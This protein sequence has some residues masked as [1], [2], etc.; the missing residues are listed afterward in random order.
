MTHIEMSCII[1]VISVL[2]VPHRNSLHDN[3]FKGDL[4]LGHQHSMKLATARAAS[5]P[6]RPQYRHE[7]IGC[8]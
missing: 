5:I 1:H 4:M 8:A 6:Q 7:I 3:F 2:I